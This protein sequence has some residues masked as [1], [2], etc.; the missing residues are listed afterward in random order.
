VTHSI[1]ARTTLNNGTAMPWLGLGV[2]KL[3]NGGEVESAIRHAL[4]IGYRSIDT[5]TVYKNEAGVGKALRESGIPREEIFLTTKLWN[6][7]QRERRQLAAFEES[8]D[9]LGLDY[10]D[11]YLVHW[12]VANAWKETWPVMESICD[13]GRASAIGVSNFMADQLEDLMAD[14][15]IVPAVNQVEF[16]PRLVQP[17]LLA[18]CR[19]HDI[20]LEAWSPLMQG[21]VTE[22]DTI[23]GIAGKYGK[24]PAQVVLR[25]DLQHGV[26]TIPKSGRPERI[27]ENA[28]I[29]DFELDADDMA[30]LDELDEGKRLGPSPYKVDF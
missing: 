19:R 12:P 2:F 5:A 9:R 21:Q 15:R 3:E 28:A 6:S 7:D 13:S 10:V 14:C 18:F 20:R 26:V 23:A 25:W 11:L 4:D 16:H 1:D 22:I 27:S 24:T 30:R 29:F 8:L 17:D